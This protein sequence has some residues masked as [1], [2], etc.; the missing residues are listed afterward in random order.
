MG[1]CAF[2]GA[3]TDGKNRACDDPDCQKKLRDNWRTGIMIKIPDGYISVAQFAKRYGGSVQG[4]VKRIKAG[5]F[6]GAF[7]DPRSGRWYIPDPRAGA[8]KQPPSAAER[9]TPR[10]FSATDRE[11]TKIIEKA[12]LTKHSV[13][14]YILRKA[15]DLTIYAG[16]GENE[17]S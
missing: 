3:P 11:W 12:A 13:S 14:E 2:C 17:K 4:I 9:R 6:E 7:Q 15:L 10:K 8:V 16:G 5:K 1:I